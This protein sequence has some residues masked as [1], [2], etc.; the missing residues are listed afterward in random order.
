MCHSTEYS[1]QN[2]W[3]HNIQH[4]QAP[5]PNPGRHYVTL[6]EVIHY[7]QA[8]FTLVLLT[9]VHKTDYFLHCH[10]KKDTFEIFNPKGTY[11]FSCAC[12]ESQ[13]LLEYPLPNDLFFSFLFSCCSCFLFSNF[14]FFLLFLP[15]KPYLQHWA[16]FDA[17]WEILIFLLGSR[18]PQHRKEECAFLEPSVWT[19]HESAE[20]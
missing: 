10:V 20:N 1:H 14:S 4:R 13:K 15:W 6:K 9:A 11:I 2:L 18:T 5:L 8:Q 17:L 16:F 3:S 12:G 19:C 7:K